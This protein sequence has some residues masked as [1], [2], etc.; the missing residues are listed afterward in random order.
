MNA[1]LVSLMVAMIQG[2]IRALISAKTTISISASEDS[3]IGSVIDS[4]EQAIEYLERVVEDLNKPQAVG[5]LSKEN[6]EGFADFL[7]L[8]PQLVQ[9]FKELMP[10]IQAII[11]IF[12][13]KLVP[14]MPTPSP[15]DPPA[16]G[17]D[18]V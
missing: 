14:P 15:V 12:K 18:V 17:P 16:P 1:I 11:A 10:M 8:I 9:T 5:L 3:P 4:I 7:A 13:T 6:V 2:V